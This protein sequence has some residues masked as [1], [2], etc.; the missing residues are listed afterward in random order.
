M[1]M[2]LEVI[3]LSSWPGPS[4]QFSRSF[5]VQDH[6]LNMETPIFDTGFKK[7]TGFY[8]INDI[9]NFVVVTLR[10]YIKGKIVKKCSEGVYSSFGGIWE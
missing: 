10:K 7:S 9:F 2:T 4:D 5:E 6:F 3:Y 1:T 8:V